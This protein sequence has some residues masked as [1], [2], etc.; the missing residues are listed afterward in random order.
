MQVLELIGMLGVAHH[1]A[2]NVLRVEHFQ[3]PV[4][5]RVEN[6]LTDQTQGTVADAHSL[7]ESL[8]SD[9]GNT[10]HHLDLLIVTFFHTLEDQLGR[11]NLPT[12]SCSNRVCTVT[13]TEN[14][15]VGT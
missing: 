7:G 4:D 11:V 2:G 8:S 9:T 13:P 3:E 10:L 14:A 12:P 6:G 5:V 15:L 1:E